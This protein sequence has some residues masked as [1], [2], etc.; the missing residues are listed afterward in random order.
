M[1]SAALRVLE[2]LGLEYRKRPELLIDRFWCWCEDEGWWQVNGSPNRGRRKCAWTA[3][4]EPVTVRCRKGHLSHLRFVGASLTFPDAG[5]HFTEEQKAQRCAQS[6]AEREG[7]PGVRI[8]GF[9]C[10][11]GDERVGGRGYGAWGSP[12]WLYSADSVSVTCRNGHLT[13]L[14]YKPETISP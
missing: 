7:N 1:T 4:G 14:A 12:F 13:C 5:K 11:C 3:C 2:D 10:H 6:T 9:R 8:A